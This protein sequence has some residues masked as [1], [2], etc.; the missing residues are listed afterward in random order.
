[1]ALRQIEL[2]VTRE[3][4]EKALDTIEKA[5]SEDD[6]TWVSPLKDGKVSVKTVMD[7]EDI[8]DLTD[9]IEKRFHVSGGY[10]VIV[11]PVEAVIPRLSQDEDREAK[12]ARARKAARL[13]REE[14]YARAQDMCRFSGPVAALVV[15]STIVAVIGLR[16]DS[17]VITLAAMI[18][19]PL[20]GPN[21]ALALSTAL[22]DRDLARKAAASGLKGT[23]LAAAVALAMG[24]V[25]Q[26]DPDAAA[27]Q[28]RTSLDMLMVLL[29]L[30][31]G[32]AGVVSFTS[33]AA[34]SLVGVMVALSILPPLAA[35]ALLTAQ[36]R[37]GQGVQAFILF[38]INVISLNLAG[39]A[40]FVAHGIQPMRWW[41]AR[42]ARSMTVKA[43]VVWAL[44][45][46]VMA[47]FV[48]LHG[49]VAR[50]R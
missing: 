8:E 45:L 23:A 20:M 46:A 42:R 14:L 1:M 31:S 50:P 30:V 27:I 18:I 17:E 13:S 35:S 43:V 19:A 2:I 29:A 33:G 25:V 6:L 5:A 11:H 26:V 4:Y 34:A 12:A 3:E 21:V 10:R 7:M 32:A 41:E 40:A 36:G 15:F 47:G 38:L 9:R 48:L 24:L 37:P 44:L 39:V 28:S 16:M 22:G 49:V